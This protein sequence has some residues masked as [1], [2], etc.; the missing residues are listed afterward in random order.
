MTEIEALKRVY[1]WSGFADEEISHED[2]ALLAEAKVIVKALIERT[3]RAEHDPTMYAVDF[4]SE[5]GMMVVVQATIDEAREEYERLTGIGSAHLSDDTIRR[6][7]RVIIA[8]HW[9]YPDPYLTICHDRFV[10]DAAEYL[11]KTY[12]TLGS[13]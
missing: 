2:E 5:R 9:K 12:T 3:E 13:A 6:A 10:A 4:L 8:C 11:A 1:S 7:M